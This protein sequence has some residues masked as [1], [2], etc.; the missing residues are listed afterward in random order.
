MAVATVVTAGQLL[1]RRIVVEPDCISGSL[2]DP[3]LD[4]AVVEDAVGMLDSGTSAAPVVCSPRAPG[5]RTRTRSRRTHE[6][7]L[8]RLRAAGV[9]ED[10]L[11]RLSSPVGLDLGAST[12]EET[13]ISIAAE[14]IATRNAASARP[15]STT[16]GRIHGGTTYACR[17]G[18]TVR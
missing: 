2:G 13:A 6:D 14:I 4:A 10:E 1:G 9:T 7:R 11:A 15:L 18:I 12:P 5:S 3:G 8:A 17:R 16:T